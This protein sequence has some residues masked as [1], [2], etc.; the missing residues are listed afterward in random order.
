[1]KEKNG[2]S[3][4]LSSQLSSNTLNKWLGKAFIFHN[5]T[6]PR[7]NVSELSEIMPEKTSLM[8]KRIV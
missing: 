5:G 8:M 2:D 7:S 3:L 1:M 6:H 4:R